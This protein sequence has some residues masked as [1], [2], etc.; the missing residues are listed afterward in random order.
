MKTC[1]IYRYLTMTIR[2]NCARVRYSADGRGVDVAGAWGDCVDSDDL[3]ELRRANAAIYR[4]WL[5]GVN[6]DRAGELPRLERRAAEAMKKAR[7]IVEAWGKSPAG[8]WCE[9]DEETAAAAGALVLVCHD[10]D[11]VT[12]R[13][14]FSYYFG[15]EG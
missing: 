5:A 7:A 14:D 3:G 4:A 8:G 12:R 1:D 6:G 15:R 10:P 9:I 11:G 2:E 13:V